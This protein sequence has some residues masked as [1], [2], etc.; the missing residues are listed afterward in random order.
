MYELELQPAISIYHTNNDININYINFDT[1]N[2]KQVFKF[3][4][5]LFYD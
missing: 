1:V 3:K 2:K 5:N 4:V